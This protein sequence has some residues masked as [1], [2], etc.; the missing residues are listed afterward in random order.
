MRNVG[1]YLVGHP[2]T[3]VGRRDSDLAPQQRMGLR[4]ER[5]AAGDI[6]N[7]DRTLIDGTLMK[8]CLTLLKSNHRR[9]EWRFITA[10][11]Y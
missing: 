11:E 10:S 6:D 5:I 2:D 1:N 9:R 7:R 4:S 3:D 8:D